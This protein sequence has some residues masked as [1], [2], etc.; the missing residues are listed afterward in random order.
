[1]D[2]PFLLISF[3]LD[4]FWFNFPGMFLVIAFAEPKFKTV[5]QVQ[6]SL[7]KVACKAVY[8]KHK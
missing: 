3:Y 8:I 6:I 7:L 1:M 2:M 5:F 4:E